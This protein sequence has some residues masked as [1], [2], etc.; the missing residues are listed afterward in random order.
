MSHDSMVDPDQFKV[1]LVA[2]DGSEFSAGVERVGIEMAV[3][4]GSQLIVLRLLMAEAGTDAAIVEE[5]DASLNVERIHTVCREKGIVSSVLLR[6]AKD[7]SQGILSVAKEVGAQLLIIG[8]RG[9]RGMAKFMVG[10]AT[11]K[12]IEK[13]ECSVLVVPR[14]FSYWSNG[15][16]LAVDPELSEGDNVANGAFALAYKARLPLTILTVAEEGG[17]DRPEV[18]Q[19]VNRLVA[20]AKMGQVDADGLVQ[21]GD[22]ND[23]ILEVARQ[24]SCDIIVCEP[25]D[26]SM[27]DRLFSANPLIHLIGKAHCPVLVMQNG[28][29]AE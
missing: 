21:D 1:I 28:Q 18:N 5:Q 6:P 24:R 10:D 15:V 2:T 8:R 29:R 17:A 16:L 23:A 25:R 9:R 3:Q 7:P 12:I 13:A 20:R 14:L 11:A 22:V 26:R 19:T 4:H 27:I